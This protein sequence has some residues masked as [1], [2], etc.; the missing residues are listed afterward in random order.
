MSTHSLAHLSS[1]IKR[2]FD[3]HVGVTWF[4]AIFCVDKTRVCRCRKNCKEMSYKL[5]FK[6]RI[7]IPFTHPFTAPHCVAFFYYLG[8]LMSMEKKVITSKMQRNVETHAETGCGNS[9][10]KA[11]LMYLVTVHG[12]TIANTFYLI[13]SEKIMSPHV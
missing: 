5:Y 13:G 12:I 9:A 6:A 3:P 11:K 2:R 10:L 8:L 7:H 4:T 1:S